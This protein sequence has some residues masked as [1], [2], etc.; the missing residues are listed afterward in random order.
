VPLLC[1]KKTSRY[2]GR[3]IES[4]AEEVN[5]TATTSALAS[6]QGVL[7][8]RVPRSSSESAQENFG[9]ETPS[10]EFEEYNDASSRLISFPRVRRVSGFIEALFY[11]Y[12]CILPISVW[13]RYF[14][15]GPLSETCIVLYL[16]FKATKLSQLTRA[17][18]EIFHCFFLGLQVC[19]SPPIYI[20]IN[21][22][23]S[24]L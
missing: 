10:Q 4:A 2:R 1:G 13:I 15:S 24:I 23:K 19:V 11:F 17:V 9:I 6:H 3:D 7:E 20:F 8:R 16:C 21:R 22:T 18:F 12:R 5:S 14:S